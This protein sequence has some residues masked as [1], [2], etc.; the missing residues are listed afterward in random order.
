MIA[1]NTLFA[2][3]TI[4]PV[5]AQETSDYGSPAGGGAVKDLNLSARKAL[6]SAFLPLFQTLPAQD[7][8]DGK[9]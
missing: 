6:L 1:L 3:F 4:Q 9:A 7:K 8:H 5:I 2:V